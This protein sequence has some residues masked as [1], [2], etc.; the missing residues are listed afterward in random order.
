M[1]SGLCSPMRNVGLFQP[2][3]DSEGRGR[4]CIEFGFV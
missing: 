2:P 1:K 3:V 4:E